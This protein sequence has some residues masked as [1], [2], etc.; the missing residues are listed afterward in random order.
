MFLLAPLSSRIRPSNLISP[1]PYL[2]PLLSSSEQCIIAANRDYSEPTKSNVTVQLCNLPDDDWSATT[3]GQQ[4][5][6]RRSFIISLSIAAD[7][8]VV[9]RQS[10]A[11]Y[12]AR[13]LG[14]RRRDE[15]ITD[16]VE[17]WREWVK[18][19]IWG[20]RMPGRWLGRRGDVEG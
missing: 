12:T 5:R 18:G 11:T 2:S 14:R 9:V 8:I 20:I 1:S 19:L 15:W 6:L 7:I 10:R 4:Q 16:G 13:G 17:G 3:T